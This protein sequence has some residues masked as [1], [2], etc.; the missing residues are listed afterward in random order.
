MKIRA[1]WDGGERQTMLVRM[2]P[3]ASVKAHG[4]ALEEECMMLAGEAFIGDTLLRR[5]EFQL[6]P[7][8]T[9]HGEVSTDVGALLFVHGVLDPADYL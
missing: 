4:H 6:A 2:A 8:G 1:L 3:G 7:Q 5:G 9:E